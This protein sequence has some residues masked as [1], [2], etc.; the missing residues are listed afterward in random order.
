MANS[1]KKE[2]KAHIKSNSADIKHVKKL[3]KKLGFKK[4]PSNKYHRKGVLRVVVGGAAEVVAFTGLSDLYLNYIDRFAE[5]TLDAGDPLYTAVGLGAYLGAHYGVPLVG[6]YWLGRGAMFLYRS[7]RE[8][9]REGRSAPQ[10]IIRKGVINKDKY[11]ERGQNYLNKKFDTDGL[12]SDDT[13]E[14]IFAHAIQHAKD[15][16]EYGRKLKKA[17]LSAEVD[18]INQHIEMLRAG[19]EISFVNNF[20]DSTNSQSTGLKVTP[21]DEAEGEYTDENTYIVR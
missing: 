18:A 14:V 12:S 1:E 19:E 10:D 13:R 5:F 7:G 15:R 3:D 6:A 4:L 9:E 2:L 8:R 21:E 20:A 16:A 17:Q 11:I